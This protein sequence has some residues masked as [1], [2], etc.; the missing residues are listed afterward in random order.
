MKKALALAVASFLAIT[1]TLA[2]P[3]YAFYESYSLTTA[4]DLETDKETHTIEDSDTQD[5]VG[6]LTD[7]SNDAIAPIVS[8]GSEAT[9]TEEVLLKGY[10]AMTGLNQGAPSIISIEYVTEPETCLKVSGAFGSGTAVEWNIYL[11]P[12]DRFDG[13]FYQR[14]Y[15]F[16]TGNLTADVEFSFDSG[17]Y[18]IER[19]ELGGFTQAASATHHCSKGNRVH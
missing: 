14:I 6:A 10:E 4:D 18:Q 5:D 16:D 7:D 17:G 2:V 12:A 11:P 3:I 15:P 13:R 19:Y 9:P 1:L 8:A